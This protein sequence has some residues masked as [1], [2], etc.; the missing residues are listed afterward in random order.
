MLLTRGLSLGPIVGPVIHHNNTLK[1]TNKNR[2]TK[3]QII[4]FYW[5]HISVLDL[6]DSIIKTKIM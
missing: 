3:K 5:I 4:V 1:I 6:P 2:P